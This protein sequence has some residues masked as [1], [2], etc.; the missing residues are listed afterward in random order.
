MSNLLVRKENAGAAIARREWD[1]FRL[2]RDLMGFDPFR[3]MEPAWWHE[4]KASFIPNFEVKETDDAYKF[5]ADVPGVTEKDLEVTLDGNRLIVAGKRLTEHEE[6]KPA[7]YLDERS[8]GQ[9]TRAFTLPEGAD[10]EHIACMLDAGVLTI[11]VPKKTQAQPRKIA[12]KAES[13]SKA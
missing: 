2:M 10:W 11:V 13:K 6:K 8:Y 5:T 7:L 4:A 3:E 9:F 12:V 1:P